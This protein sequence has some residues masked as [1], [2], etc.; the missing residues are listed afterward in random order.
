MKITLVSSWVLMSWKVKKEEEEEEKIITIIL[1]Q[2]IF[3]D[4]ADHFV[5]AA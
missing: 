5:I 4:F 1:E 3:K 2:I